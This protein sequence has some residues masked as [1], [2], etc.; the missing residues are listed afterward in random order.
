MAD[1]TEPVC[2]ERCHIVGA[3]TAGVVFVCWLSLALCLCNVRRKR[4]IPH[5]KKM[6]GSAYELPATNAARKSNE[7]SYLANVT[8]DRDIYQNASGSAVRR[9]SI[10]YSTV[11]FKESKQSP[12][13]K[14]PKSEEVTYASVNLAARDAQVVSDTYAQ[15]IKKKA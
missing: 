9:D 7:T 2:E 3:I 10:V 11:V 13:S 1:V 15:V 4:K 5:G 14:P 12:D 8:E 6:N